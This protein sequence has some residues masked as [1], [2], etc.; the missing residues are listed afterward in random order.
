MS[1]KLIPFIYIAIVFWIGNAIASELPTYEGR[2]RYDV[3]KSSTYIMSTESVPQVFKDIIAKEGSYYP[4]SLTLVFTAD[5]FGTAHI[6]KNLSDI[7]LYKIEKIE[8]T[9]SY[10]RLKVIE[11]GPIQNNE[12]TI[13]FENDCIYYYES[14]WKFKSYFC[15][16]DENS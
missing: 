5:S 4:N 7:L 9:A 16:W 13:F 14:K 12:L 2:W 1:I 15:K 3:E 11:P 8:H 10:F 6:S